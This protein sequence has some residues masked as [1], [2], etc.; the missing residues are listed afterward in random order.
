MALALI[1]AIIGGL[2]YI[3]AAQGDNAALSR[4]GELGKYA[5]LSGLLAYLL[6]GK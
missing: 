1:V 5:F 6:G 4:V 3:V 2:V